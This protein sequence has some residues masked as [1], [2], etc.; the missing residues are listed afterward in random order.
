MKSGWADIRKKYKIY[1]TKKYNQIKRTYSTPKD[2]EDAIYANTYFMLITY[3][4]KPFKNADE[5]AIQIKPSLK[6]S[7]E[8][9]IWVCQYLL[10]KHE[11]NGHTVI[12]ASVL[13]RM[14]HKDYPD[15]FSFIVYA[16][17]HPMFHY[18]SDAKKVSLKQ[19]F[20]NEK[21]I[22]ETIKNRI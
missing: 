21:L 5:L 18:D 6:S 12:N 4:E 11:G 8:R 16:V 15:V 7:L 9:C 17:Q 22:A 20:Y 10:K 2:F 1:S 3:L 19:T 14:V 13:A